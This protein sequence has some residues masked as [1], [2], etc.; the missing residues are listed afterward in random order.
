MNR[1]GW[2]DHSC[3]RTHGM[4]AVTR[5]EGDLS[6]FDDLLR[7]SGI[8]SQPLIDHGSDHGA[9]H[10]TTHFIPVNI[11]SGMKNRRL[12]HSRNT[13]QCRTDI[14]QHRLCRTDPCDHL[15]IRLRNFVTQRF[16]RIQRSKNFLITARNR[17]PVYL[18]DRCRL[19]LHVLL[20]PF[21]S[22]IYNRYFI[23]V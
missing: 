7:L 5:S 21:Q 1:H 11:R 12:G 23:L 2:R 16:D 17:L 6:F 10:R 19:C 18:T 20:K 13:F 22:Y 8:G 9:A 3:H 15:R 14:N 4:I